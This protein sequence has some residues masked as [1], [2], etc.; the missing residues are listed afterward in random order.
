MLRSSPSVSR[1][2][3]RKWQKTGSIVRRGENLWWPELEI[4]NAEE[5]LD[6]SAQLLPLLLLKPHSAGAPTYVRTYC[7]AHSSGL[8]PPRLLWHTVQNVQEK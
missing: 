2:K 4:P 3:G 7:H 8:W 1:F 6:M 5:K